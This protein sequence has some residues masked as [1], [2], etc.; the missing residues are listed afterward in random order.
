MNQPASA[1]CGVRALS[2]SSE[3]A[4]P[5][6]ERDPWPAIHIPSACHAVHT[7]IAHTEVTVNGRL[8]AKAWQQPAPATEDYG[9]GLSSS[10]AFCRSAAASAFL[11]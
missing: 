4:E 7:G 3:L 2:T 1:F 8:G 11:P 6:G 10:L 9:C 5:C